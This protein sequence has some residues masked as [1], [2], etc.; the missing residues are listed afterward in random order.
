MLSRMRSDTTDATGTL[1]ELCR[2]AMFHGTRV[3]IA[4]A[5]G[6][7]DHTINYDVMCSA[8]CSPQALQAAR[9]TPWTLRKRGVDD[10]TK[11]RTLGF[12]ALHLIEED[13]C[14]QLIAVLSAASVR[15]AFVCTAGDAVAVA[16]TEAQRLLDISTGTLLRLCVGAPESAHAVLKRC[17]VVEGVNA[18]L[19]D[20]TSEELLDTCVGATRLQQCGLTMAHILRDTGA[21][22]L[23]LEMMGYRLVL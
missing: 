1:D 15:E 10:A 19:C 4:D 8:Q 3:E 12:D 11:F 17:V 14:R 2:I 5:V 23:Q 18:V 6:M 13:F 7:E 22:S 16:G 20:V 21:S 9:L